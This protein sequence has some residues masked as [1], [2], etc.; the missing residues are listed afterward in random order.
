[1]QVDLSG[2]AP[3]VDLLASYELIEVRTLQCLSPA[4]VSTRSEV[5]SLATAEVICKHAKTRCPACHWQDM[6]SARAVASALAG[7]PD[8]SAPQ[9]VP[10]RTVL[11][12]GDAARQRAGVLVETMRACGCQPAVIAAL[13][14]KH[15]GEAL[16]GAAERVRC[17]ALPQQRHIPTG[18]TSPCP[19]I[20]CQP[21]TPSPV[22]QKLSMLAREPTGC[23]HKCLSTRC[24]LA[25]Q[26]T[27]ST[28]SCIS[29]SPR[30]RST[31]LYPAARRW[32]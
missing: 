13:V 7:A 14:P 30:T 1:M 8:Q 26:H 32:P 19:A 16:K 17:A 18:C 28:T 4:A 15:L 11:L 25:G 2:V 24:C 22:R 27:R 9:S 21:K 6:L 31:V 3:S 10:G 12:V 23:V 5:H 20:I 29:R